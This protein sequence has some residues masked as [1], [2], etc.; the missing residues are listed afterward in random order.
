MWLYADCGNSNPDP[1]TDTQALCLLNH[2]LR[3]LLTFK[4]SFSFKNFGVS[5]YVWRLLISVCITCM[6]V[7]MDARR[8]CQNLWKWGGSVQL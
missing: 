8:G 3:P 1:L 4:N 7:P 2:L 6:Q 5:V